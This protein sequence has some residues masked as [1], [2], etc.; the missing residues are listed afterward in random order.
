ML[1]TKTDPADFATVFV[2]GLKGGK[3]RLDR[4]A[5]FLVVASKL[6]LVSSALSLSM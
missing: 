2:F 4:S 5:A 1:I 6:F 3:A